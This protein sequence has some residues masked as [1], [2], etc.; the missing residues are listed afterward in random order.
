MGQVCL[1]LA[2]LAEVRCHLLNVIE[3]IAD[4]GDGKR[5]KN[6]KE[7]RK[8]PLSYARE[9]WNILY[10]DNSMLTTKA[11]RK[12]KKQLGAQPQSEKDFHFSLVIR[13]ISR[14]PAVTWY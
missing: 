4:L 7:R 3:L 1:Y 8:A 12:D 14:C 6:W 11:Q 9:I 2:V 13:S 5:Q 10:T